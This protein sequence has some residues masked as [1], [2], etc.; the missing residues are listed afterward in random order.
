MLLHGVTLVHHFSL[1]HECTHYTVFKT[2]RWNEWVGWLCGLA[3]MLAPKYFRY[4]HCDHHTWTQQTGRDPE[5]IP[6]PKTIWEYAWYLSSVPYWQAKLSEVGRHAIG[7]MSEQD[8][9]FVPQ[10]EFAAIFWEARVLVIVYALVIVCMVMF[11]W[12]EPLYLWIIPV[13]LGEPVMRFIRMTE[14]VGMPPMADM[15]RNT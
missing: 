4:E 7:R 3:I 10:T 11:H 6:L 1:Q 12:S 8:C 5:Q 9:A 15:R 2:R 14:H 13:V